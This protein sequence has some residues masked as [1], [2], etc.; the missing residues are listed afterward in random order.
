MLVGTAIVNNVLKGFRCAA[1]GVRL[2]L[3]GNWKGAD[4]EKPGCFVCRNYY[5]VFR[6]KRYRR[7]ELEKSSS[8]ESSDPDEPLYVPL[9]ERRKELF[10]KLATSSPA[11]S[12]ISTPEVTKALDSPKPADSPAEKEEERSLFDEHSKA[13]LDSQ[14][15]EIL[16]GKRRDFS[17]WNGNPSYVTHTCI[18]SY[19]SYMIYII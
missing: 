18:I 9:K 17:A 7:P 19:D 15:K 6:M 16:H 13:R 3:T 4:R 5:G 12:R 11:S 2:S 14:K 8:S 10:A 1:H